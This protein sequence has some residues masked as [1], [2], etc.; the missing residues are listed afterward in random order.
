MFDKISGKKFHNEYLQ[1]EA[2]VKNLTDEYLYCNKQKFI[3][4]SK[5]LRDYLKYGSSENVSKQLLF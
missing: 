4:N 3:T 5:I 1:N 2:T